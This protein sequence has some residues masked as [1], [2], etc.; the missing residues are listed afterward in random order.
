MLKLKNDSTILTDKIAK[1]G[2]AKAIKVKKQHYEGLLNEKNQLST[3]IKQLDYKLNG[4]QVC[5]KDIDK[6][7][8]ANNSLFALNSKVKALQDD[9]SALKQSLYVPALIVTLLL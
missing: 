5:Q 1:V 8:L 7:I 2:N 6:Y 4:N 9:I 3:K